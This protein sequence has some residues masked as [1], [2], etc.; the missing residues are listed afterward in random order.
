MKVVSQAAFSS[1][2]GQVIRPKTRSDLFS[3]NAAASQDR[4]GPIVTALIKCKSHFRRVHFAPVRSI[5]EMQ[6]EFAE[7]GG[8]I[9]LSQQRALVPC[10]PG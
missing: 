1:L 5:P 3:G 10:E 4:A 8:I 9:F 6:Q 2:R 7:V